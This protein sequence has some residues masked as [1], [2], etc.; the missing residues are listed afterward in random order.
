MRHDQILMLAAVTAVALTGLSDV[1]RCSFDSE[2]ELDGKAVFEPKGVKGGCAFFAGGDC[3]EISPLPDLL[4]R[5]QSLTFSVWF[6]FPAFKARDLMVSNREF[7][8]FGWGSKDRAPKVDWACSGVKSRHDRTATAATLKDHWFLNSYG[9]GGLVSVGN[10][11]YPLI[12]DGRWHRLVMTLDAEKNR[13]RVYLDGVCRAA[14]D[15]TW[16]FAVDP[17][18]KLLV[19]GTFWGRMRGWLD[20]F[21]I[22]SGAKDAAIVKTEWEARDRTV[23]DVK[24]PPAPGPVQREIRV[25]QPYLVF[26]VDNDP[27]AVKSYL[28]IVDADGTLLHS[29]GLPIAADGKGDWTATVDMRDWLG[30]TVTFTFDKGPK[31]GAKLLGLLKPSDVRG[32]P[33]GLYAEPNR[34]QFHFSPPVG[35]MNDPNGLV[36]VDGEWR[37][38]YQH[39]PYSYRDPWNGN[40]YWGYATSRDLVHWT[41]RGDPLK[42]YPGNRNLISGS[43]VIDVDNTAGFGRNAHIACV[44]GGSPNGYGLLLWHSKDGRTYVPYAGNPVCR[45]P[46]LGADPKVQW[47]K[48]T[49]RWIMVTHGVKDNCYCVTFFS[50]PDL[51]DWKK[52]SEYFGDHVSKGRQ[53]FLHECPGLEELK[54]EGE[55]ATAW[56]V[57]CAGPEYAVG[58]FDG[59]VFKPYEE[60]LWSLA[61]RSTA[62]YAAQSFQN[63]PDGRCVLIPWYTMSGTGPHFNQVLGLPEDLALKRT[64]AGLRMT[65][66]PAKELEA[67][68]DGPG[69]PFDRF[70][71]ELVE[72]R[73]TVEPAADT[74]VV[75]DLRGV[76]VVYDAKRERLRCAGEDVYW[77]LRDG[78]LDLRFFLD[79]QG[80]EC[81]SA[82]GLDCWPFREARP[83]P[84]NLKLAAKADGAKSAAFTAWKLKPIWGGVVSDVEVHRE[85]M[86]GKPDPTLH[87]ISHADGTVTLDNA[88][89]TGRLIDGVFLKKGRRVVMPRPCP[90]TPALRM[91]PLAA[92]RNEVRNAG[93]HV[94]LEIDLANV[95]AAE[96]LYAIPGALELYLR[97]ADTENR[98]LLRG[99]DTGRGNYVNFPLPDGSCPILEAKVAGPAGRVGIPLGALKQPLGV[100][101]VTLNYTGAHW[102]IGVD[103]L[104]DEDFP[105]SELAWPDDGAFAWTCSDRVK[106]AAFAPA[107]VE[108]LGRARFRASNS[109]KVDKPIQFFTPPDHDTWV[110]DVALGFHEGRFHVFY[111]LDR[112]HHQSKAGRGGHYFAHLSSTDLRTWYEHPPAAALDEKWESHGTGTPFAWQGKYYLAYGLHTVRTIAREKT[113]A[114]VMYEYREKHGKEG[115]F[116][117]ADLAPRVPQGGTYAVSEDGGITFRKS[118]ELFTTAQNP[119]VYNRW[120][121]KLGLADYTKLNWS[122]RFGDWKV[123][124]DKIPTHGDCPCAFEWNGHHYIIQGFFTMAYS[125][126]GQPG[127]YESLEMKGED[128]YDGLAVPMVAPFTGN[129]RILAGWINHMDGWGGWL[130]FRELVQSPDGRLGTKWL[131]EATLP[132]APQVWTDVSAA[133]PFV[134]RFD[135]VSGQGAGLEFRIDPAEGRAQFSD[136]GAD[137]QAPRQ[138]SLREILAALPPNE[139]NISKVS[140]TPAPH[141]GGNFAIEKIGEL[142]PT[143]GVRM[144]VWYDRKADVTIFDA[145][146]AGR[147]TLVCRRKGEYRNAAARR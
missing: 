90:D 100:K 20:E 83:K 145:E 88:D 29:L 79:R 51:K 89:S 116:K 111:L 15:E 118:Y 68:R 42:P 147:R 82:S 94:E 142:G 58:E 80:L 139:R 77:P 44:C 46:G 50:S 114:P 12:V 93:F 122:D 37:L 25:E 126:S 48:G 124:D 36:Y 63:A 26:P 52:E 8:L 97:P 121:G 135:P 72:G 7:G 38:M 138:K 57:W 5:R 112:R 32:D 137:G 16:S 28:S 136:V 133:K 134:V 21:E 75:L 98:K 78:K 70:A 17:N 67:L 59:H 41:H 81:F 141:R 23:T 91:T 117:M 96:R 146:I 11:L 143:F 107:C 6:R 131:A 92:T 85:G 39:A 104:M 140:Q 125:P 13:R 102:Q 47:H 132:T 19:G 27:K 129:R 69:V 84:G 4:K 56:V 130:C 113:T 31:D 24:A 54:I 76:E 99:Y 71:G 53:R 9:G 49:R 60:R 127:T 34:L 33:P 10:G 1:F 86:N 144:V 22:A 123:W 18:G 64:N 43:G 35:F 128:I 55:D 3:L 14:S 105:F 110:G 115:R 74:T 62:Y 45:L 65:R 106:S 95:R 109:L 119:T 66:R 101:K 103:G 30:R 2:S 108:D 73:V 120:D 87:Y 61:K 40:Q